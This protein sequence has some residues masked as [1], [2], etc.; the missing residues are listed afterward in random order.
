MR[1]IMTGQCLTKFLYKSSEGIGTTSL[2]AL[3]WRNDAAG[4]VRQVL[5][6]FAEVSFH[7]KKAIARN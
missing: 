7:F 4:M 5:E 2:L 3:C 6:R 1:A